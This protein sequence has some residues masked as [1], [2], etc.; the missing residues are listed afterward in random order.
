MFGL[1]LRTY[2]NQVN[3]LSES[4]TCAG[5]SLWSSVLEFVQDRPV[6]SRGAILERFKRDDGGLVKAVPGDLVD[7]G[8]VFHS[9]TGD[10]VVYRSASADDLAV[11]RGPHRDQALANLV[12]VAV[13]RYGPISRE[14]I[15]RIVPTSD[16]ELDAALERLVASGPVVA[17]LDDGVT[18][19]GCGNTLIPPGDSVGWEA[20]VF[21]HYQAMVTAICTKLRM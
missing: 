6:V 8:L 19:Y 11:A 4:R 14:G 3:R 20:S 17:E 5:R 16:R 1:T 13:H 15:K 9:G 7:S 18:R 21:D 10:C 2:Y 12:T